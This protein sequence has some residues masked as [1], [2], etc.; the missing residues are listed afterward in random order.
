MKKLALLFVSMILLVTIAV[1]A[2]AGTKSLTFGWQQN[3]ADL[4]QMGTG[5][6]KL[7][8]ADTAT[9]PWT[10]FNTIDYLG[11]P[12]NEYTSTKTL[13]VP[14][15]TEKTIYFAVTASDKSGNESARSNVVSALIDFMAPSVPISLTVTV[16]N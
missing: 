4:P 13:T 3:A 12:Q 10:L 9:G 14:D 1:S 7:Y 11:T 5:A 2:D 16:T 15:G 8:T 6:W